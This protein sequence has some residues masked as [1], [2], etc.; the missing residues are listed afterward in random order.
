MIGPHPRPLCICCQTLFGIRCFSSLFG[1]LR[2]RERVSEFAPPDLCPPR[3]GGRGPGEVP[4]T[5]GISVFPNPSTGLFTILSD[6]AVNVEIFDL[7]GQVVWSG[8]VQNS[9]SIDLRSVPKGVY[10]Y[11]AKEGSAVGK[12]QVH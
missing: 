12:L 3:G 2:T 9:A 5:I 11:K 7:L 1:H 8:E 6:E 4:S 10:F